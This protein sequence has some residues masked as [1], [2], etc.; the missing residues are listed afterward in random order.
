MSVQSSLV[1]LL[2]ERLSFARF[3]QFT[4]K[5]GIVLIE[6]VV[7]S[8]SVTNCTKYGLNTR[9]FADRTME[10]NSL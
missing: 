8:H 7:D 2:K 3:Q 5:N 9:C 6:R 1:S 10:K 4:V